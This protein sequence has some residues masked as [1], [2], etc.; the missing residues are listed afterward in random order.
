MTNETAIDV[1]DIERIEAEARANGAAQADFIGADEPERPAGISTA[2]QLKPLLGM[3]FSI[4]APNWQVQSAE[5]DALADSYGECLDYYYPELKD[6][7]PPW[8]TPLLV[9]AAI[10]GPRLSVPRVRE[11]KPV[12]GETVN[13][14]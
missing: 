11:E 4:L 1:A 10:I 5:V 6:G 2:D 9:T 3:T 14:S 8:V 13:G 7:L 12:Q